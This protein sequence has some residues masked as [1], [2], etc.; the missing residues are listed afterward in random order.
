MNI[1]AFFF[2]VVF[3]PALL[4]TDLPALEFR[5]LSWGGEIDDL[6]YKSAS[7]VVHVTV[8]ENALSPIYHWSGNDRLTFFKE[9]KVEAKTILKPVAKFTPPADLRQAI[10]LLIPEASDSTYTGI[11]MDDSQ[12]ARP[13]QTITYRNLSS[14]TIGI[15]MGTEQFT[16]APQSFIVHPTNAA[17][18]RVVLKAAAQTGTGWTLIASTSQSI[19][20]GRRTLVLLRNGRPQPNGESALVDFVLFHDR[21]AP[22]V[23]TAPDIAAR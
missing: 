2:I 7:E 1:R 6:S 20:T 21:P 17:N 19:R 22:P 11:W 12:E 16:V 15:Q 9:I 3:G 14:Y 4:T 23:P 18:Q 5:L 10:L 8:G 13:V